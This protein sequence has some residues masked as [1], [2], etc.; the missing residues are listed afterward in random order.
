MGLHMARITNTHER[1]MSHLRRKCDKHEMDALAER[2][3]C[4]YE[5]GQELLKEVPI[6]VAKLETEFYSKWSS[7]CVHIDSEIQVALLER[8][9]NPTGHQVPSLKKLIEDHHALAPVSVDIGVG[10]QLLH[11]EYELTMKK[12]KYDEDVFAVWRNKYT[13]HEAAIYNKKRDWVLDQNRRLRE[14][15]TT[16]VKCHVKV[17]IWDTPDKIIQELQTIQRLI[18]DKETFRGSTFITFHISLGAPRHRSQL[19]F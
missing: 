9:G 10:H 11:D 13:N 8:S 17:L 16:Q 5:L 6:T 12:I 2:A 7:G 15:A 14:I 3:A 18:R 1:A 4:V 19:P